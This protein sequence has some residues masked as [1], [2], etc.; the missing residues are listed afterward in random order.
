MADFF[1][2]FDK[3][4]EKENP[5]PE[6]V[7]KPTEEK[8]TEKTEEKEETN[9]ISKTFESLRNEITALKELIKNISMSNSAGE[10]DE[11]KKESE[12]VEE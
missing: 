12:D 5:E 7:K 2:D 8:E 3:V 10:K 6:T 1:N 4:N 9:D 11:N